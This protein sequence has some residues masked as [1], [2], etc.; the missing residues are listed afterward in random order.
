M[1]D[2]CCIPREENSSEDDRQAVNLMNVKEVF[3]LESL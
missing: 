3:L 1:V 2:D